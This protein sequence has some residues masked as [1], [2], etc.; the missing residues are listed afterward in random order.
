[1]RQMFYSL[2][3]HHKAIFGVTFCSYNYLLGKYG[4]NIMNLRELLAY[5]IRKKRRLLGISQAKL[6]EKADTSTQYVA[7]I[8]LTRK[9]PSPEMLERIASALELEA[10][11]LFS[12]PPSPEGALK[13]LLSPIVLGSIEQAA[14]EAAM[15]AVRTALDEHIRKL[16]ARE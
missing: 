12:I 14:G 15:L 11:E 8:E 16:E 9:F 1:M 2:K 6:A 4:E 13:K 10:Q 3:T 5:N 7:M